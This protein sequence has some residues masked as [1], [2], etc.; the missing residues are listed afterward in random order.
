MKKKGKRPQSENDW[1]NTYGDMVTLLLCF[2]VLLYSISTVDERKW[3]AIV[4]SLNPEV[5][6]TAITGG[7]NTGDGAEP[8]EVIADKLD[9][10]YYILKAEVEKQGLSSS[11]EINKG[12]GFAFISFQNHVFFDGESS[13]LKE[14]G[15][16]I[17][18]AFSTAIANASD[19][20]KEIQIL[21]HTSQAEPEMAN[22]V[23]VDRMLSSNRAAEVTIYLQE[24][25]IVDPSK[26]VCVSYGQH[27][28]IDT[29]DTFEGRARNRRVELL[30]TQTDA[31]EKS[32]EEYYQQIYESKE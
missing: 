20:I 23:R 6:E 30:I 3:E 26:L 14:E 32:L 8:N 21:G 9:Q 24:K 7:A 13:I 19:E 1:L 22:D 18:D 25:G 5:E 29:F 27:R 31:V 2:F 4:K 11:V 16:G 12:D 17:L 15:K 10:L 28:P